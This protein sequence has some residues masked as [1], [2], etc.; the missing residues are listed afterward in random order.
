MEWF[1][2]HMWL[3]ETNLG[4]SYNR[5]FTATDARGLA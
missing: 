1:D 5:I 4:N 3:Q 2:Q